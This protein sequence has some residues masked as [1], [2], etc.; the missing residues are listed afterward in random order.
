MIIARIR[1]SDTLGH[2][3]EFVYASIRDAKRGDVVPPAM[4]ARGGAYDGHG[5]IHQ[6]EEEPT[7]RIA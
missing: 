4:G 3:S 7:P 1:D 5:A 6:V 2:G